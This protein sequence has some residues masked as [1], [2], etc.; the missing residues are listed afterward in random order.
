MSAGST[1]ARLVSRRPHPFYVVQQI[2]EQTDGGMTNV[3]KRYGPFSGAFFDP[4]M[5][6]PGG[7]NTEIEDIRTDVGWRLNFMP[8]VVPVGSPDGRVGDSVT[9]RDRGTE[10]D[11]I[12]GTDLGTFRV[13]KC[14]PIGYDSDAN[15]PEAYRAILERV[16]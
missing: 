1:I 12:D 10:R 5:A 7:P 15:A 6:A 9:L 4:T 3:T 16:S 14:T 8:L 13:L 2:R 11:E